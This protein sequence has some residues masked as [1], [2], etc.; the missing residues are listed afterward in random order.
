[1]TPFWYGSFTSGDE[2][3]FQTDV[4]SGYGAWE[5][6]RVAAA[7]GGR[8]LF[9]PFPKSDFLDVLP[10]DAS[11]LSDLAPG[12]ASRARCAAEREGDDVL[13]ALLAAEAQVLARTPWADTWGR[14]RA[15]KRWGA[16]SGSSPLALTDGWRA[17]RKP[18]DVVPA[19]DAKTIEADGA[20]LAEVLPA[21]E[22]AIEVLERAHY[23]WKAGAFRGLPRRD[24]ALLLSARF[25]YAM[26]AFHLHALS[27][28]MQEIERF[29]PPGFEKHTLSY[30]VTYVPT[31]RMSDVLEGY[32]RRVLSDALEER[33]SRPPG[34]GGLHRWQGN[35]LAIPETDP[36]YRAQR[37]PMNVLQYLD[38]RLV[39][40]ALR[41]VAAARDVMEA[42][43]RSPHGAVVYYSEAYT[44]VWKPVTHLGG[45]IGPAG[46]D[47]D[48]KPR[49]AVTPNDPAPSSPGGPTS[50]G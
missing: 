34:A 40:A 27:L 15:A 43:G 1:V 44:F 30:Y 49:P 32:E 22:R 38:P 17:R 39:P 5:L 8:Y 35:L 36:M 28:Y 14:G 20:R 16:F 13:R 42:Y 2:R 10:Y 12:Y 3:L 33:F 47:K 19:G 48:K 31:I 41:M 6:A 24:H 18:Y 37:V 25:D 46:K 9:Y 26:S 23:A 50:G 29:R 21:Y 11:L 4:P 45:N 7:T